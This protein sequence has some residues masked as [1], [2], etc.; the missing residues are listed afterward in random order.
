MGRNSES[1]IY[2]GYDM[3]GFTWRVSDE[4]VGPDKYAAAR[5]GWKLVRNGRMRRYY[6][7]S[8]NMLM[9]AYSYNTCI[10][11]RMP[12]DEDFPYGRLVINESTYSA[13]S[14]KHKNIIRNEFRRYIHTSIVDPDSKYGFNYGYQ[15]MSIEWTHRAN[16]IDA[17]TDIDGNGL[18]RDIELNISLAAETRENMHRQRLSRIANIKAHNANVDAYNETYR[19]VIHID[20]EG[21]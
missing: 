13:T 12:P 20:F 17:D 14:E 18:R 8:D 1:M 10:M 4:T 15:V 11:T 16:T 19:N 21:K 2:T 9:E 5:M 6:R 3:R 7:L